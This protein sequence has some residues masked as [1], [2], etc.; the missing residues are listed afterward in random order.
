M[1]FSIKVQYALQALL[2]LAQSYE[3]GAVQIGE[4]AK[5]QQI[6]VRFLEQLLLQMK[7]SGLLASQRGMLGGYSLAKHPSEINLLEVVEILEGK[8]EL[9]GKRMKKVPVLFDAM[10]DVQSKLME[11]LKN[12]T[13]EDLVMKKKQRDRSYIYNI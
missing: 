2:T 1:K 7:K 6:P 4:I 5:T 10:S 8:I 3:S 9:A 12:V 13:I 11:T